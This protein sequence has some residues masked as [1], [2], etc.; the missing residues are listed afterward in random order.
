MGRARR[1][2]RGGRRDP[3]RARRATGGAAPPAP[4]L[5]RD[6][7]RRPGPRRA[8]GRA[9]DP[10]PL[11]PAE[12]RD[13]AERRRDGHVPRA[14]RLRLEREAPLRADLGP[15]PALRL[16]PAVL[17]PRDDRH[18]D[19]GLARPRPASRVSVEPHARDPRAHGPGARVH[20]RALR[21]RDGRGGQGARPHGA[22]PVDPVDRDLR[23]EPRW[24][25]WPAAISRRTC[26]TAGPSS[27]SRSSPRSRSPPPPGPCTSPGRAS[28]G[29][30]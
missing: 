15:G 26:P 19:A 7:L 4:R 22:L 10:A 20:R 1:R 11:L 2:C 9:R 17:S 23:G 24:R 13:A 29:P 16:P 6:R 5:L 27:W 25:G 21:R 18:G 28:T 3:A 8:E 14:H 30:R 12:G